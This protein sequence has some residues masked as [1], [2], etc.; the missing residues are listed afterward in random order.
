MDPQSTKNA[1]IKQTLNEKWAFIHIH[2]EGELLA[3]LNSICGNKL[4]TFYDTKKQK[5]IQFIHS[6]VNEYENRKT[7]NQGENP[8]VEA[9]YAWFTNKRNA[10]N[11]TIM[12]F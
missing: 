4:P 1:R 2:G 8:E 7:L 9:L 3:I 12:T 5:I 10:K 6:L 11:L